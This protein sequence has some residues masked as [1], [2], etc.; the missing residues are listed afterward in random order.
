M[1]WAS[2][3]SERH[4]KTCQKK[5]LELVIQVLVKPGNLNFRILW[6]ISGMLSCYLHH[7]LSKLPKRRPP[8]QQ[9]RNWLPQHPPQVMSAS[10]P[11]P[12]EMDA[13]GLR[14]ETEENTLPEVSTSASTADHTWGFTKD[15]DGSMDHG[16]LLQKL[17]SILNH[18][19]LKP[20]FLNGKP[21]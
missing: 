2:L 16:D 11:R 9:L 18:L 4:K 17:I 21:V 13:N 10:S 7:P 19:K 6:C 15:I 12:V 8:A 3:E 1:N 20:Q 5:P 14:H